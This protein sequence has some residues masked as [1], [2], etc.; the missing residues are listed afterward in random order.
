[1]NTPMSWVASGVSG[2]TPIWNKIIREML[3]N[4]SNENWPMPEGVVKSNTCGRDEYFIEGTEETI[5]C[6]T[7]VT[8]TPGN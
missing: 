1:D 5:K 8:P 6:L 4:K 7:T 3:K 2:A